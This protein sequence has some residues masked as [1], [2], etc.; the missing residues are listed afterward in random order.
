MIP[1]AASRALLAVASFTAALQA[2][3]T[4]Q[5]PESEQEKKVIVTATRSAKTPFEVPY[6]ADSITEQEMRRRSYRTVP[7][8]LRDTTGVMVQETAH[9]HGS[10]YIRGFTSFRTLMLID[11]IRLNN[12]AFRPGP[13]QYWN[14]VDG[15]ALD[16]LEIVKGPSSVL[17]GSDAIGGTVQAITRDPYA[18]SPDKR[19]AWAGMTRLRYSGAEDSILARGEVSFVLPG[20]GDS[21]TSFLIGAT[22]RHFGDLEGGDSVG[23]QPNTGY[24]E[25]DADLKIN[26]FFD[27]DTRL[28]LMHQRVRQ[29]DVP[30]T[31]RTMDGIAWRGLAVGG[32]R[33]RMFDQ[34]RE[35]T[36]L[37]FHKENMSGFADTLRANLSWHRQGEVRYRVRGNGNEEEQGFDVH[38]LGAF[39]QM[40]SETGI[41]RLSYGFDFYRDN[42]DSFFRNYASPSAADN[43][44]GPIADDATYDLFDVYLQDSFMVGDRLELTLGARF[45][46]VAADAD[47]VRD[48]VS[49]TQIQLDDDW[50]AVVGSFRFRYDLVPE[51]TNIFGGVS[52]GFRAPNLSDLSRFDSARSG[53]FEIPA[54]GLD[55]ENYISYELGLKHRR[56]DYQV[57]ASWFYTDISD[58]ILRFPTG[59]VV[60]GENE[61][62]KD[63]VGDGYI[64][65][66]ELG[67]AWEVVEQTTVF[68]NATY[69][70]GR[71]S[72]FDGSTPT[73]QDTYPTR[74]MPIT[75]QLGLRYEEREG[76]YWGETVVVHAEEQDKLSFGDERD[77]SRIP[78]GGT[79]GYTVWHLRGGIQ[80]SEQT[81]LEILLENVTDV[82]YR[83]HGS[84]QNR[85]GRNVVVGMT[86]WF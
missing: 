2:Q 47:S 25:L 56:E 49:S 6:T 52:Q 86:T 57:Q 7:Q 65:G 3:E 82:D 38:T 9:G 51:Q 81:S 36:Y 21:R 84:G 30:R 63:N 62:T 73:L 23:T 46:Y 58:Q 34:N 66:I 27:A 70:Y 10:P 64:Q 37:Q 41:G 83:I 4:R 31:H 12:A 55:E 61:V 53:E 22:A 19:F 79:P 44:Q 43:I 18:Y 48:P 80:L 39:L 72:N 32:D 11:G 69:M 13:N 76:R 78:P 15:A 20:E 68:G 67:A 50:N 26:H 45:N 28:V 85:P 77:T 71:L 40:E 17:Y 75:A 14:T 29:D 8:T 42:V 74:M 5:S 60:G 1:P 54:P 16:R 59:N 24:D 33:Q 35:L